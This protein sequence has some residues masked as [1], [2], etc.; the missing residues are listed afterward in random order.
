MIQFAAKKEGGHVM[1]RLPTFSALAMLI[2]G[3]AMAFPT[4]DVPT[5]EPE[6]LAK[7][8]TGAPE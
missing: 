8:K 5:S 6:Y 1:L 4:T 7:V 2:A 3:N